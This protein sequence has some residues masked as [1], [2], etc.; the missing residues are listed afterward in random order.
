M[1]IEVLSDNPAI[2]N[3]IATRIENAGFPVAKASIPK[4]RMFKT[5]ELDGD[6]SLSRG[7][8]TLELSSAM[9]KRL[10]EMDHELIGTPDYMGGA[11]FWNYEYR[12]TLRDAS[13]LVRV[14]VHDAWLAAGLPLDGKSKKHQAILSREVTAAAHPALGR[15]K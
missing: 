1:F 4:K 2:A 6:P 15:V 10:L 13:A 11:Y 8:H 3:A 7:T 12:H 14:R 9:A 5:V